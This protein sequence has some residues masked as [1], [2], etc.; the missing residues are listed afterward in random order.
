MKK[1]KN[2]G[3][4][5]LHIVFILITVMYVLPLLMV[6]SVS[7]TDETTLIQSGYRLIPKVFS[8]AAYELALRNPMKIIRAYGVTIF[9]TLAATLLSTVVMAMLAYPMSR[10]NFIWKKQLNFFVYFTMLFSGGM[11]PTY[12]L[13]TSVLHLDDK[14]LVYILPGLVS[15]Y[16]VMIIRTNYQSIPDELIE[17]AKIDGAKELYICFKI[18]VPLAKPGI[19]SV[20]F[21]FLVTKWN[22]WMTSMLYIRDP[23]LYSLQYLLQ[24]LIREVEYLKQATEMGSYVGD[25]VVP[26]ETLRF[27]MAIIAAGPVLV[28][29]PFFQKYF[30]KG[31]TLGGV[32]G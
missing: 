17:A 5:C 1:K 21:L 19:A 32:K 22:D 13:L 6:I 18:V 9:F 20:A 4:I 16:N 24:R 26:T 2:L 29:F 28:A 14:I 3:Q 23:D 10:P 7:F 25:A 27:A 15:A 31:M 30:T 8:T 11:V 12:I